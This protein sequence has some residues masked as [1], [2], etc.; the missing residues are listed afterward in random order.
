[1]TNM[2]DMPNDAIDRGDP[3]GLHH[4][5]P[6]PWSQFEKRRDRAREALVC[7][8]D[9]YRRAKE[10]WDAT[11]GASVVASDDLKAAFADYQAAQRL[12]DDLEANERHLRAIGVY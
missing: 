4:G 7:A 9:R 1:M 6:M 2:T 3:A 10:T 5:R 11:G 12:V 8:T